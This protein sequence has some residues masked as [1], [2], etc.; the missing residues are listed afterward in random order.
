MARPGP[1][2]KPE[3]GTRRLARPASMLFALAVLGSL[4]AAAGWLHHTGKLGAVT[5]GAALTYRDWIENVVNDP[6]NETYRAEVLTRVVDAYRETPVG[7]SLGLRNDAGQVVGRFRIEV[8]E[9]TQLAAADNSPAAR[10]RYDVALS[11]SGELW[12]QTG[13]RVRFA[14]SALVTYEVDFRVHNW[15]VYA[16]FTCLDLRRAEF[17]CTHIDHVLGQILPGIVRKAGR[18]AL[19]ESLRPGFTLVLDSAGNC[20]CAH[21]RVGTEFRPRKGPMPETDTDCETLWNDV[22]RLERGFR[23]YLGPIELHAGEELRVTVQARGLDPHENFGPDVLLLTESEFFA[24]EERY[25]DGFDRPPALNPV[26]AG[27]NVQRQNFEVKGRTGRF[28]LDYTEFGLSHEQWKRQTR[29]G[30]VEYYVRAR[31]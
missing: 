1:H 5:Q 16:W 12:H 11:G 31:R 18:E 15:R 30:L 14:G 20:W 25:P 22:S 4:A 19:E 10:R 27:Y 26:E 2:E 17:E 13:G 8:A 24:Y 3:P 6:G 28:Y 9:V 7:K 21:G 29:P 23:D